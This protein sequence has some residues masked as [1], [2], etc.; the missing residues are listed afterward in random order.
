MKRGLPPAPVGCSPA[1]ENDSRG[2]GWYCCRD[3]TYNQ[4]TEC[5]ACG[6]HRCSQ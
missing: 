2:A 4:G 5:R 1:D 6:H 3:N